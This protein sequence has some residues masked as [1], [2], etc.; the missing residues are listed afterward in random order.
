MEAC[1]ELLKWWK[2]LGEDIRTFV[3]PSMLMLTK[4]LSFMSDQLRLVQLLES[5]HIICLQRNQ[6]QQ[7]H[8]STGWLRTIV[9]TERI[10]PQYERST[11]IRLAESIN[12]MWQKMVRR[13]VKW[14][15]PEV[16]RGYKPTGREQIKPSHRNG[17]MIL[18]GGLRLQRAWC[19]H[20]RQDR[21]HIIAE[22][23]DFEDMRPQCARHG[24]KSDRE[25][26][27]ILNFC[28]AISTRQIRR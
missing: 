19:T 26:T 8:L 3:Y 21:Q 11:K 22:C 2:Q 7:T 17:L 5:R 23:A 6:T 25:L 24:V 14:K 13:R 18:S 12:E 1:I 20:R 27:S 28:T 4:C 15:K 16:L 10:R 9:T